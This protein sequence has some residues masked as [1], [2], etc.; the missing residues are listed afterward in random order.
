[1][2]VR[3]RAVR[4]RPRRRDLETLV[5]IHLLACLFLRQGRHPHAGAPTPHGVPAFPLT[6]QERVFY[7]L[8]EP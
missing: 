7:T 6:F 2:A 1:M 5:F 8:L 3:L 4:L